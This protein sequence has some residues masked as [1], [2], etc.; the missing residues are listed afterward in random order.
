MCFVSCILRQLP[1]LTFVVYK[2]LEAIHK[3]QALL[4]FHKNIIG[5][6]SKLNLAQE[7][8]NTDS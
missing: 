7:L 3:L 2:H 5:K 4:C 8:L 1:C 6:P